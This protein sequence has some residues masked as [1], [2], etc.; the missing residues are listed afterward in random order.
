MA[1]PFFRGMG[2]PL[3]LLGLILMARGAT[4]SQTSQTLV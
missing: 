4:L 2:K 1:M 3:I